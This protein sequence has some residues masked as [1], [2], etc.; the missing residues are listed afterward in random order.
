M[1]K[2]PRVDVDDDTPTPVPSSRRLFETLLT[3]R[4]GLIVEEIDSLEDRLAKCTRREMS[5]KRMMVI[6][7]QLERA[8]AA[9]A[10]VLS[11][12]DDSSS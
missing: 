11:D 4:V 6:L 12:I 8:Q 7:S 10:D 9:L 1:A 2:D 5:P 3:Y